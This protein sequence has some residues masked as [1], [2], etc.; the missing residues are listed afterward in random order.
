MRSR[1]LALGLTFL[2]A[3][4]LAAQTKLSGAGTCAKPDVTHTIAIG[5][6]PNH[7]FAIANGL[8]HRHV[9]WLV[10]DGWVGR[11]PMADGW[12]KS[13]LGAVAAPEKF[14]GGP[15]TCAPREVMPSARQ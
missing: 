3:H 14:G 6:R 4:V 8:V 7:S 9:G 5:D 13:G 15:S 12:G 11:S 1:F 2:G 10:V